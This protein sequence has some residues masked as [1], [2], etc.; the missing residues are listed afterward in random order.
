MF[1]LGCSVAAMLPAA[2]PAR[3]LPNSPIRFEVN[4]GQ[5]RSSPGREP[6]AWAG[7]GLGYSIGFTGDATL[8]RSGEQIVTMRLK[9]QN[10]ISPFE[11]SAPLSAPTNYFIPGFQGK[12]QDFQRLRR[13][14][15]YPGVDLVYYGNGD[16]LEYDFEIAAGADPSRIRMHFDGSV[17]LSAGGDLLLGS[18]KNTITQHAPVV[19]QKSAAG[20]RIAVPASYRL[21]RRHNVSFVFESYDSALPLVIDPVVEF[22]AYLFGSSGDSGVVISHDS[23]GFIYAAG[24]TQSID[25]GTAPNSYTGAQ[26]GTQNTWLMKINPNATSGDQVVV[27]ST[28]YGGGAQDNVT[29]MTTDGNGWIYIAGYTTSTTLPIVSGFQTTNAGNTDG[30]VAVFDP[31]QSGT[32]SLLYSTYVGGLMVDKV[33]AIA[34]AN[35]RVY[36]TGSTLSDNFPTSSGAIRP[37]RGLGW[38]TFITVLNIF[39]PG[40]P[41]LTI[42]TY[43]GGSG[44]DFGRSIAVDSAGNIYIAGQTYSSDYPISFQRFQGAYGGSGDGFLSKFDPTVTFGLYSTYFGGSGADDLRAIAIDPAGRVSLTGSTNS[45]DFAITQNAEQ[46]FLGGAGATNAFLTILDTAQ[47]TTQGLIYSTYFGGSLVEGASALAVDRTG[48]YYFGGYSMSADMPVTSNALNP[49]IGPGGL[50]GF[51]AAINPSLPPAR[52]LRYSSFVTGAG[53]QLVSGLDVGA[54]GVIYLTGSATADIFPAGYPK[55]TAAGN[56]DAFIFVFTPDPLP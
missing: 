25:F 19:Y 13:H 53:T 23:Q 11:P 32:P 5:F 15:V 3:S 29:G 34:V 2:T 49:V 24:N 37:L 20:E 47:P 44:D 40:T 12:V 17:R 7:L 1:L 56:A 38:D 21:D 8:F 42:S 33:S 46:P 4:R 16:R 50:N 41:S 52:S 9:G 55:P 48:V 43:F 28:L 10:A 54:N 39:N 27:Y 30:F 31:S 18:G 45:I 6:I 22:A 36:L 14:D 35:N 26:M 51:V